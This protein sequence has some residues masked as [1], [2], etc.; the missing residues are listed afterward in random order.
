[1][2]GV[3][4][5]CR[6]ASCKIPLITQFFSD[7]NIDFMILCE[8][9]HA[10]S[11]PGKLDIF[12]A[13]FY[14]F[15]DAENIEVSIH[16]KARSDD[17]RG[18]GV[19]LLFKSKLKFSALRLD[20]TEPVS[21]EYVATKCKDASPFVLICVYRP[22]SLSFSTFLQEFEILLLV[23][24]SL[25]L[26][27]VVA[28]DFNIHMNR[29]F[30]T[31]TINFRNLLFEYNCGVGM[32]DQPSHQGGNTLDF[33]VLSEDFVSKCSS[34]TVVMN[35]I[36]V[37][38]HFPVGFFISHIPTPSSNQYQPLKWYRNLKG[39]NHVDFKR[40]LAAWLEP[41]LLLDNAGFGT[42]LRS[43]NNALSSALDEHAPLLSSFQ[44]DTRPPWIDHEYREA[45]A[46]RTRL[47]RS[48]LFNRAAYN[49]QNRLC[50]RMLVDKRSRHYSN[51]IASAENQSQLFK[52]VNKIVGKNIHKNTLPS[53]NDQKQLADR[54]NNFFVKKVLSIRQGLPSDMNNTL[55]DYSSSTSENQYSGNQLNCFQPT[56]A[57]ELKLII[58]KY[59]V[60]T[61]PDDPLPSFI[62][63]EHLDVELPHLVR[64]VNLSLSDPSCDGLKEANVVP[65]LKSFKLDPDDCKS[66][67]PVSLLSFISKLVERVVHMR[68]NAH[69][70]ENGLTSPSQYGY[71]KDH[72]CETMLVKLI[73]DIMIGVNNKSGVVVLI[74]DLSAAFD[75]VDHRVLLNILQY[76]YHISGVAL[77]WI[78]SF[79]S[80]RSQRVKI[81]E[82]RSASMVITF[83]VPQGSILGPLLF[84]LYCAGID[85]AFKSAGFDS[86][87]YADDNLGLRLFPAFSSLS[88]L[89]SIIPKC[90]ESVNA[91]ANA[92]FL[93]LNRDKTQLMVFGD[94]Q[95]R[96]TFNFNSSRSDHGRRI[97]ISDTIK[98]LGFHLDTN[99]TFSDH[100]SS[101]VSSINFALRNLRPVRK[102]LAKKDAESIVHALITSKLDQCNGL[103]LGISQHNL[104]KL[105]RAQNSAIRYV[106]QLGPRSHVSHHFIEL[107]WL[108]V[109]KRI[110]FKFLLLVFKCLNNKAPQELADKLRLSCAL[111]M[112]LCTNTF[113]P[114]TAI[115][116]RAFS[117]LGPRLWNGLP[118]DLRVIP[119]LETF[120]GHLKTYLFE[121]FQ[122]YRHDIDPYTTVSIS[123]QPGV[124][125]NF[126]LMNF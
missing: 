82:S 85:R 40:D 87:G 10:E 65:I 125:G 11:L 90:I 19:A 105:Q 56:D 17:Q 78:K 76:K 115:G 12:A 114:T 30:E 36:L 72:S 70:M 67:R 60:K 108:T 50:A 51:L 61:G 113:K 9:W 43:Y 122:T 52:V 112:T 96:T 120:K 89:L 110:Y 21:Y 102:F 57:E 32:S 124:S 77:A 16:S 31:N 103:L 74:V 15:A 62:V 35:S 27:W 54:F 84:N 117:Y 69:L 34:F 88:T 39:I 47:Q 97:P 126:V 14:D 118:R 42:Y 41:L 46:L 25:T 63:K 3:I 33:A 64:L 55:S 73:D 53:S 20:L 7:N 4:W 24:S 79:L 94:S 121:H 59:G 48:P 29:L 68:I 123:Q 28:G 6:S 83:G 93:K 71:K 5:N 8:T 95:F 81:G 101:I 38:D 49:A 107:H 91:W 92:H 75:T 66:Y 119:A 111:N 2:N 1:M 23:L 106:L 37:S 26:P 22:P 58:D 18:G 109:E 99:L 80:G 100:V 44:S 116:R 98:L 13:T 45:R 86:M 104:A